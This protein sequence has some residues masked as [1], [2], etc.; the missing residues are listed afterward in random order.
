MGGIQSLSRSTYSKLIPQSTSDHASYFSFFDVTEKMAIVLGTFTYG[1]IEQ[2]TG[3]MRN[4]AVSLGI[5]FLVGLGF[6]ILVTLPKPS[7][8]STIH[9]DNA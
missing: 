9:P 8:S 1:A 5:F 2:L 6:L 3:S 7:L 4:S